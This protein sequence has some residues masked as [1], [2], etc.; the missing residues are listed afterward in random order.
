[1]GGFAVPRPVKDL[2]VGK[3]YLILGLRLVRDTQRMVL[4][5][6]IADAAPQAGWALI[7][8]PTCKERRYCS[9]KGIEIIE[10]GLA[11]FLEA[12]G[13]PAVALAS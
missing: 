1:M 9:R 2:R 3:Q 13:A 12:A 7:P 6:L 4:S 8:E 5:D 11:E 10:T